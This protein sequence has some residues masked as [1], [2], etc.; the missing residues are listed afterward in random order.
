M[1]IPCMTD[2]LKSILTLLL[3][4]TL[5]TESLGE[6]RLTSRTITTIRGLPSNRVNDLVQDG[7]GFIWFGTSNGLCRFDGYSYLVFPTMGTGAGET[8]AN[9][10]T[11][12]VDQKN[13]LMWLRSATFNYACY[14]LRKKQYVDF[15]GD[16]DPQKTFERFFA[17]EDGIWMY[18]S[19]VGI[20]HVKYSNGSFSC[21][22]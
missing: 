4:A 15:T 16:C 7:E 6:E 3:C 2:K 5:A 17:E 18:E 8:N 14:D 1:K 20:R 21:R 9:V 12:H 19:N 22:D 11:I 10:G 13:Q